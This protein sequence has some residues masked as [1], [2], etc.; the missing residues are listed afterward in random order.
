MIPHRLTPKFKLFE[1]YRETGDWENAFRMAEI[2]VDAPVK[3]EGTRVLRMKAQA[4]A[5]LQKMGCSMRKKVGQFP[6]GTSPADLQKGHEFER[7]SMNYCNY[8]NNFSNFVGIV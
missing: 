3:K 4:D 5:F 6:S 2:V 7:F 1:L 8:D